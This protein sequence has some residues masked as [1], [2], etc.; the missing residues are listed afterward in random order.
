MSLTDTFSWPEEK[1]HNQVWNILVCSRHLCLRQRDREKRDLS[2]ITSLFLSCYSRETSDPHYPAVNINEV[3]CSSITESCKQLGTWQRKR[4]I[5]DG[6]LHSLATEGQLT[7][8]FKKPEN[9]KAILK[10]HRYFHFFKHC[11]LHSNHSPDSFR[12]L[13]YE[14]NW[15]YALQEYSALF[16]RSQPCFCC[17][18]KSYLSEES[19][20]SI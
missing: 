18:G 10:L 1:H 12:H 19:H 9:S 4:A 14:I 7:R 5:W 17:G 20:F 16:P 13:S 2:L 15:L 8:T 3:S 11:G 6:P